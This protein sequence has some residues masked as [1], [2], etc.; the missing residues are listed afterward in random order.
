MY[1]RYLLAEE[2]ERM[3][4]I[5]PHKGV[6]HL[7][8]ELAVDGTF[9][10][11]NSHRHTCETLYSKRHPNQEHILTCCV[12]V[13]LHKAVKTSLHMG[14]LFN[15]HVDFHVWMKSCCLTVMATFAFEEAVGIFK[16]HS[17]TLAALRM[18]H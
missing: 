11:C 15:S 8:H 14:F 5:G 6:L 16:V 2:P 13:A 9:S 1:E 17:C 7:N 4:T 18:R 10:V 12:S 3:F